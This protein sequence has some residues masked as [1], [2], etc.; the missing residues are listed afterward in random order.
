MLRRLQS[1]LQLELELELD[2]IWIAAYYSD[3]R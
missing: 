1:L 2:H 3:D